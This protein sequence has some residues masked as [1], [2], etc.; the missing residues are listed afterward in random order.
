MEK[1]RS[2]SGL[3]L[4]GCL[5]LAGTAAADT[6]EAGLAA[7]WNVGP[8][9]DASGTV[10]NFTRDLPLSARLTVGYHRVEAGDP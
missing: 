2:L 7:G 9:L 8:G 4:A 10:E 5:V 6:I 3:V 1:V